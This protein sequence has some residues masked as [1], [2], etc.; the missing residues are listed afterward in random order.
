MSRTIKFSLFFDYMR[1]KFDFLPAFRHDFFFSLFQFY[2]VTSAWFFERMGE[3]IASFSVEGESEC[4]AP[5]PLF[6][7]LRGDDLLFP[8]PFA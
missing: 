3:T 2:F 8:L 7:L 4:G 1:L 6:L 5:L